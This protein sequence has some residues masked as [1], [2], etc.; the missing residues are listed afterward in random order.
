MTDME[1]LIPCPKPLF[2]NAWLRIVGCAESARTIM[3]PR[4]S[5]FLDIRQKIYMW[6]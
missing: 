1:I 2:L 4:Y 6:I 5:Q 3:F